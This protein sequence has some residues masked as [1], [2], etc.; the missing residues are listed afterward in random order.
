MTTTR[1][2][3]K[4][5]PGRASP[6]GPDT[7]C[8]PVEANLRALHAL[9]TALWEAASCGAIGKWR[10]RHLVAVRTSAG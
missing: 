3:D 10:P 5:V 2:H 1:A 7:Y 8:I 9:Y 6:Y 4:A